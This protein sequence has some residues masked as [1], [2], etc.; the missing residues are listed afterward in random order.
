MRRRCGTTVVAE[1]CDTLDTGSVFRERRSEVSHACPCCAHLTLTVRGGFEICPVCF[2]EDDGQDDH[3]ADK[4]RG[5]PNGDRS[6]HAAR[7]N[8]A[9][10]GACDDGSV[11]FVRGPLAHELPLK[12]EQS[13]LV[14]NVG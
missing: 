7:T 1:H 12:A 9:G 13:R 8:Y 14:G 11:Q 2:W 10:C 6:L 4:V 3:D 5:G